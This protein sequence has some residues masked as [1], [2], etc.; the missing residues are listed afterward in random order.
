MH[1]LNT[2][3]TDTYLLLYDSTGTEVAYNDDSC[4]N[5]GSLLTYQAPVG[6][7]CMDYTIREGCQSDNSCSGTVSVFVT[8]TPS[9]TPAPTPAPVQGKYSIA[10]SFIFCFEIHVLMYGDHY[11]QTLTSTFSNIIVAPLTHENLLI[12]IY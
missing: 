1:F 9:P 4:G 2:T 10:R 5:L 8:P 3:F 6:A 11:T 12:E 7:V